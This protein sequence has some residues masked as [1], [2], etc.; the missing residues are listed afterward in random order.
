MAPLRR[1][2]ACHR[3]RR[4]FRGGGDGRRIPGLDSVATAA[5]IAISVAAAGG[6]QRAFG[7]DAKPL[8]V[9]MAAQAGAQAA[10]LASLGARP[11]LT[12]LDTWLQLVQATTAAAGRSSELD[13]RRFRR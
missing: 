10:E 3:D 4:C 2:L 9:G 5:A 8:Q 12:A 7:S 13:P 1:G 11:D 6:V